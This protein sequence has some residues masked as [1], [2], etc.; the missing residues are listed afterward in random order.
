MDSLYD[1][2]YD[3]LRWRYGLQHRPISQYFIGTNGSSDLPHPILFSHR[4]SRDP[5]FPH[6]E[7]DWAVEIPPRLAEHHSLVLISAPSLPSGAALDRS[8]EHTSELQ[9]LR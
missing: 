9:S 3:G 7:A 1:D 4:F 2:T 8:E 5:R 6:G